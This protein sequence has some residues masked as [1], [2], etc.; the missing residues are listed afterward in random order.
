M[1]F[2]ILRAIWGSKLDI[3]QFWFCDGWI[4]NAFFNGTSIKDFYKRKISIFFCKY[5]NKNSKIGVEEPFFQFS[6][7]KNSLI[8]FFNEKG[9]GEYMI[10]ISEKNV[11]SEPTQTVCIN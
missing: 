11:L 8:T 9:K 5:L 1:I 3:E 10:W 2:G 6:V 4:K 7:L